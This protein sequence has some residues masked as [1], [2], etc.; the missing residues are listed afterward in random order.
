MQFTA[1]ANTTGRRQARRTIC[2]IRGLVTKRLSFSDIFTARGRSLRHFVAVVRVSVTVCL[3]ESD[4][5]QLPTFS[6][7]PD[8]RTAA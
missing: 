3:T 2:T 8:Q 4:A 1:A 6:C 7:P 5:A